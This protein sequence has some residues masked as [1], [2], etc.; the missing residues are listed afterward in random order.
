MNS[1]SWIQPKATA[2]Q[3]RLYNIQN[4]VQ[5]FIKLFRS[6]KWRPLSYLLE[7]FSFKRPYP[8]WWQFSSMTQWIILWLHF[9]CNPF[10]LDSLPVRKFRK[11]F[12]LKFYSRKNNVAALNAIKFP[13]WKLQTVFPITNSDKVFCVYCWQTYSSYLS[14]SG[15]TMRCWHFHT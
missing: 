13:V 5:S 11:T 12:S 8:F 15:C 7:N 6:S 3:Q 2:I 4:E 14:A 1:S 10:L 9:P